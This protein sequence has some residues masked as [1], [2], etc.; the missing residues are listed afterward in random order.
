MAV[1]TK[2]E[3]LRILRNRIGYISGQDI[4]ESLGISRTAVWKVINQLKEEGYEI[5]AVSNKGYRILK[6]PNIITAEEIMSQMETNVMA[7]EVVFYP[8][9]DSTNT[10]AK[11]IA[12]KDDSHGKLIVSE[13][14]NMG[15]GRR[16]REWDSPKGNGIWMSLILRPKMNP[17]NASMLTLIAALAVANG[18]NQETDLKAKIKWPNDLVIN[19]KKVCGILTEMSSELDYINHI[20]VGIGINANITKFSGELQNMATSISIQCGHDINRASLISKVMKEFEQYYEIFLK[21][22]SLVDIV[23]EYNENLVHL[24][25]KVQVLTPNGS[26]EVLALGIDEKGRLLVR[27]HSNETKALMSGEISIRGINGYV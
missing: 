2:T 19:G 5:E 21:T 4:C 13:R 10:W 20:V 17:S 18:I 1:N 22:E 14:Q 11:K 26:V 16:G 23:K 24:N 3:I 15:R 6:Y 7:R 8:E 9:V 25:Q 27:N 12:E